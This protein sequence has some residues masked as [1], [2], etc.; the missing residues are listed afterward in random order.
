MTD[1][2]HRAWSI[3]R[4]LGAAARRAIAADGRDPDAP[5]DAPAP[6]SVIPF[7]ARRGGLDGLATALI[8]RA[9]GGSLDRERVL[10]ATVTLLGAQARGGDSWGALPPGAVLE[11]NPGLTLDEAAVA[12]LIGGFTRAGWLEWQSGR[13]RMSGAFHREREAAHAAL[14]TAMVPVPPGSI[15][16]L[17]P[18]IDAALRAGALSLYAWRGLYY[19]VG[20]PVPTATA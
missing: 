12:A 19:L 14:M 6:G 16:G 11:M 13:A 15:P 4:A 2:E 3:A 5:I 1:T 20:N 7:P 17:D 18:E 8:Y 9:L 10:A